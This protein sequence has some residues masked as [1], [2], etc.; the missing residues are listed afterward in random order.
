MQ[1]TKEELISF[2]RDNSAEEE[3]YSIIFDA[4]D[5]IVKAVKF[6]ELVGE[7]FDSSVVNQASLKV[8]DKYTV[9]TKAQIIVASQKLAEKHK[10]LQSWRGIEQ[11]ISD[12]ND[13]PEV[14]STLERWAP[15]N[16]VG[17]GE[18]QFQLLFQTVPEI[19]EP[20]FV[21]VADEGY[22]IKYFGE[23]GNKSVLSA[24][25]TD[26]KRANTLQENINSFRKILNIPNVLK[27]FSKKFE[28]FSTSEILLFST[29]PIS[30]ESTH[31]KTGISEKDVLAFRDSFLKEFEKFF[32]EKDGKFFMFELIEEMS[33]ILKSI[34]EHLIREHEGQV[35][36]V[37]LQGNTATLISSDSEIQT[38]YIVTNQRIMFCLSNRNLTSIERGLAR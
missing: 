29:V 36:I 35:G 37:A 27:K 25:F 28:E 19:K 16:R 9:A 14:N 6:K 12:F 22:S 33:K 7:D 2:R 30:W 4:N 15:K 34:R 20:D 17:R 3:V 24:E 10:L 38:Q 23:K 32:P 1:Q 31:N 18:A 5:D 21:P 8:F 26:Q 11:A 13:C